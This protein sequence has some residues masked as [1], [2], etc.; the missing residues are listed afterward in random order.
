[1]DKEDIAWLGDIISGAKG[2]GVFQIFGS[3]I[4]PGTLGPVERHF[5]PVHG[6]KVLSEEFTQAL[7]Q[8]AKAAQ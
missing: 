4:N 1:M 7:K 3:T 5:F 6:K 2:L 8:V